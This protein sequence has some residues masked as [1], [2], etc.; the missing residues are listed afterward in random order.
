M[1]IPESAEGR[2]EYLKQIQ[3]RVQ[4]QW[5]K[6]KPYN[7]DAPTDPEERK[8]RNKFLV[9]FPYPYM[10]GRLHLGHAF[11]VAKAEFAVRFQRLLGKKALF[12]FGFHCTGMPILACAQRL[13]AEI[14]EK[15]E[16]G[17]GVVVDT[18]AEE[19]KVDDIVTDAEVAVTVDDTTAAVPAPKKK[20][21]K[22]KLAA[23]STGLK[24]QWEIMRSMDVPEEEIP[25]FANT[26]KWLEYWPPIARDDLS[27]L[28]MA[29][30]WRRTFVTTDVNPYYD[31]FIKWQFNQLRAKD[32][33]GF[34][35]MMCV[36]ST[37]SEAN[38][39]DHD[40]SEGEGVTSQEY[41]LVKLE[42]QKPYP[43]ELIDLFTT[44]TTEQNSKFDADSMTVYLPAATL[45]P[46]T[47][48]GQTNAFLKPDGEYAVYIMNDKDIFVCSQHSANNMA[49][50]YIFGEYQ[51]KAFDS[52][53]VQLEE[54]LIG[55]IEGCKFFGKK[56]KCAIN[57][58]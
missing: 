36:Y 46:E 11:T 44:F 7:V 4:Q 24:S 38:C 29:I 18:E 2:L 55:N 19:A 16:G 30:D 23:K 12:P 41:T 5:S 56:S 14:K 9:T 6:T 10:N 21:K 45:R 58:V 15:E 25:Q 32:K 13:Q 51:G 48:Y 34:G 49:Y 57:T 31:A 52:P 28:G 22:G 35:Q 3:N 40:R 27:R 39:A 8:K 47:M 43:Q 33:I 54:R 20:N 42:L 1:S 53:K 17:G 50:Q 26:E 37:A